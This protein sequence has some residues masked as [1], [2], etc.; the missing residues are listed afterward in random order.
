MAG[1]LLLIFGNAG[2]FAFAALY[3]PITFCGS[4]VRPPSTMLMMNQMDTDTGTVASLVGSVA[5]LCGSFAMF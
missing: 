5:L 1:V 4:A 3:L 2:P